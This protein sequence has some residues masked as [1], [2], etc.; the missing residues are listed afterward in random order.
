MKFEYPYFKMSIGSDN[1]L[2]ETE[3]LYVVNIYCQFF[4]LILQKATKK[5]NYENLGR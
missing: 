3:C 5:L 2:F 4:L 1:I